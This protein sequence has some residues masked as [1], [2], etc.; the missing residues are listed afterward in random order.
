MPE[1]TVKAWLSRGRRRLAAALDR[2]QR[3]RSRGAG[4]VPTAGE[5]QVPG[6]LREVATW[7]ESQVEPAAV[8][9]VW[10]GGAR[11]RARRRGGVAVLVAGVGVA[12][13]AAL[14]LQPEDRARV[15]SG[16]G[17]VKATSVP[18]AHTAT[19]TASN[20]TTVTRRSRSFVQHEQE[21][22]RGSP[23]GSTRPEPSCLAEPREEPL[24]ARRAGRSSCRS[25]SAAA[26]KRDRWQRPR[27][28]AGGS[29]PRRPRSEPRSRSAHP[30]PRRRPRARPPAE[31]RRARIL[32]CRCHLS[33]F[34]VLTPRRRRC[35]MYGW[36]R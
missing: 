34:S 36:S 28:A 27:R 7:A 21:R 10:R 5:D 29:P 6:A 11:R 15:I 35:M 30:A 20:P 3:G 8:E 32:R 12:V 19:T 4:A 16:P 17:G 33:S 9:S 31:G 26:E 13:I 25:T 18:A 23:S 22:E 24:E 1:G 2:E 14:A